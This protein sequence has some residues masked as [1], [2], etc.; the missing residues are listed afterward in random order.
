MDLSQQLEFVTSAK[1]TDDYP[2][3][4]IGNKCDL[5]NA[6]KIQPDEGMKL[7]TETGGLFLETSAKVGINVEEAFLELLKEIDSNGLLSVEPNK[8][9]KCCVC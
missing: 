3:V 5:E 2:L 1:K 8:N 6:R 7:A 9:K 4:I